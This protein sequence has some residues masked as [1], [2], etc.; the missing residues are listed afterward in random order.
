MG[1]DDT[2]SV[3]EA[4]AIFFLGCLVGE[5]CTLAFVIYLDHEDRK[6]M[7]EPRGK[8]EDQDNNR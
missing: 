6:D 7:Y 5:V 1:E 8:R 4:W 2:V 3:V